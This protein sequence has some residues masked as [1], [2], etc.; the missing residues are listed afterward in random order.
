MLLFISSGR[1]SSF[2]DP[3]PFRVSYGSL[4]NF[5]AQSS[6]LI[7]A[8]GQLD[9]GLDEDRLSLLSEYDR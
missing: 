8:I 1:F 5:S 7:S 4:G 9:E 2:V 3:F 6:D